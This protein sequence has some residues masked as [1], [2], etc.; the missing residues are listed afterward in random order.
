MLRTQPDQHHGSGERPSCSRDAAQIA[1][2]I[3]SLFVVFV[4]LVTM[5]LSAGD[6]GAHGTPTLTAQLVIA[7]AAVIPP[8]LVVRAL[9]RRDDRQAVV[10]FR[11]GIVVYIAWGVLNDAA[12][13]GWS[14]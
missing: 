8:G 9:E 13:H 12:V 5:T 7:V 4:A 11:I 14:H 3:G 2:V 10:W 1:V 6:A